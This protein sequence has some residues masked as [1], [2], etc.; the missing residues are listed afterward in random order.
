[1][2]PAGASAQSACAWDVF[3]QAG[4]EKDHRVSAP[5]GGNQRYYNRLADT[6]LPIL[7]K[8]ESVI[9]DHRRFEKAAFEKAAFKKVAF[10]KVAFEK[11]AFKKAAFKKAI[12]P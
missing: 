4:T 8:G 7:G 12:W 9:Q 11:A 2:P 3:A 1:M 5:P 10:K 6:L